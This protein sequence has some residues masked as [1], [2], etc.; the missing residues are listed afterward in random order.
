VFTQL[1]QASVETDAVR[2]S[3]QAQIPSQV[4]TRSTGLLGAALRGRLVTREQLEAF[5]R[6]P[7]PRRIPSN[8]KRRR[9]TS[10]SLM[11]A[12]VG[13]LFTAIGAA[14]AVH[15]VS[16]DQGPW[17]GDRLIGLLAF[18][19]TFPLLG[20]PICLFSLRHRHINGRLL[21]HGMVV[22]AVVLG[23]EKTSVTINDQQQYRLEV[24]FT[25]Q[26]GHQQAHCHIYGR[27]GH[28]A[29]E[30]VGSEQ[31]ARI[32]YDPLKPRR[33]LWAESLLLEGVA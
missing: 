32:L 18:G 2:T 7:P 1:I 10:G 29:R 16:Y 3:T 19:I 26:M 22:D 31:T 23:V 13:A 4:E 24:R 15:A 33:L 27:E 8:I 21:K 14:F 25:T 6:E 20:I 11:A 28:A 12:F 30:L 5:L 9:M 17:V